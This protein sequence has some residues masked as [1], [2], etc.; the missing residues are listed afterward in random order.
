MLPILINVVLAGNGGAVKLLRSLAYPLTRE[1]PITIENYDSFQ[2]G[3]RDENKSII[4]IVDDDSYNYQSDSVIG[5]FKKTYPHS[6]SILISSK[7]DLKE[8]VQ[9]IKVGITD[10]I[11]RPINRRAFLHTLKKLIK[12][13][14]TQKKWVSPDCD[15]SSRP[16]EKPEVFSNILTKSAKMKNI[17][18]YIERIAGSPKPVLITGECGTGKELIAQ[19]IHKWGQRIGKLV[20]VNTAGLDDTMFSDTLFGHEKGAYTGASGSRKGLIE[21]ARGGSLFLDEIG[22]LDWRNQ[23]KLLRLIQEGEYFP[24]GSDMPRRTNARI[25]TATHHDLRRGVFEGSFREDLYYRLSCHVLRIPPLRE[26]KEDIQ[27]LTERFIGDTAGQLGIKPPDPDDSFIELLMGWH[28][29]GNI[30]ELQAII[31]DAV[32]RCRTNRLEG[33]Y[34]K[35]YMENQREF[36]K[37]IGSSVFHNG[38]IKWYGTIPNFREVKESLIES[39]LEQNGG[40]QSKAATALGISQAS[41]SKYCKSK[42][43]PQAV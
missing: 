9:K 16:L 25:I 7:T 1:Y 38:E 23:I 29:P 19:V 11:P 26:R 3:P 42:K 34:L 35:S 30:R 8:V 21:N 43:T 24:L 36:A 17:F 22:D 12:Q 33:E 20:S 40:N 4:F 15:L 10:F 39:A 5:F 14:I 6:D 28:F 18:H 2:S 27:L 32:C 37:P 41:I 31:F 13:I